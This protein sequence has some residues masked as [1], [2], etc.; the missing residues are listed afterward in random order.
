MFTIVY[1]PSAVVE[2]STWPRAPLACTRKAFSPTPRQSFT[3]PRR[4]PP[5]LSDTVGSSAVARYRLRK[6][7]LGPGVGHASVG[8][9]RGMK[10]GKGVIVGVFVTVGVGSGVQVGGIVGV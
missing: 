5:V 8:V 3:R 7:A 9:T 4:T 1:W 2:V 6:K 10:V